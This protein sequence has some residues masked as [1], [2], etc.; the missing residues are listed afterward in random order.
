MDRFAAARLKVERANK[1]I[2]DLD[3]IISALPKAYISTVEPNEKGGETI[4]YVA[5]DVSKIADNMAV[6]IGDAIHNLRVAVEYSYLGAIEKH[7]PSILDKYTKFPVGKTRKDVESALKNRKIDI[8]CPKLFDRILAEIEPYEDRNCLVV[9]LH[10]LDVRDKHWLLTPLM[11]LSWVNGITV[12]NE[13]GEIV[14]GDSYPIPGAGD[15]FFDFGPGCKVK[16]KGEITL[17]VVFNDFFL[18]KG[19]SITNDLKDFA[20]IANYI[21]DRL[22]T[23]I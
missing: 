8:L 16:D 3:A 15:F 11:Q 10:D 2:A 9:F 21:I 4:K 17:D 14:T 7:V 18:L 1:H 22:S 12:Q 5:P 23:I 6:I 13:Q 20:K 19:M